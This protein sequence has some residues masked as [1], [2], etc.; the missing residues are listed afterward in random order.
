MPCEWEAAK[1]SCVWISRQGFV[2]V[3]LLG[4]Y[5]PF[6]QLLDIKFTNAIIVSIL[7]GAILS[8]ITSWDNCT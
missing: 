7:P 8:A 6:K 5:P 4:K 2:N 1:W 3:D